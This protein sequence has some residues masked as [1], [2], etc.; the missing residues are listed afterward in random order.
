[1]SK[2]LCLQWNEFKDNIMDSFR[3]LKEHIYFA[4]ATLACDVDQQ[5]EAHN[6]VLASSSPVFQNI[7]K[8]IK[9]SYPL[10]YMRGMTFE[11]LSTIQKIKQRH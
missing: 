3:S 10:L 11:D 7:L 5:L 8:I 9:H 2:K 6:V 1:M 4:D